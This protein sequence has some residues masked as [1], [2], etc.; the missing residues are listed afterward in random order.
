MLHLHPRVH[1]H[2]VQL[3]VFGQQKLHGTGVLVAHGLGRAH[4]QVADIGAL[5]RGQLRAGSDL[6]QLLVAPLNRAITLKQMHHVAEAVTE[7][8]RLDVLG[9]NDAFF[10]KHFGAAE[11]LGRL[12]DDPWVSLL[13]FI[14]A[15]AAPNAAPAAAVGGLEHYRVTN[16]VTFAQGFGDIRHVALG[17]RSTGHASGDHAAP[18]FGFVAHAADHFRRRA[19]EFDPALDANIRQLGI[20][21]EKTIARMQRITAGFHR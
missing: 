12:G 4:G 2:K 9:I 18:R 17:A 21:R 14:A 7:N 6:D 10:Q 1:L 3:A 5:L 15:V 19:D 8:L 16:A 13:Q 20:F 11:G